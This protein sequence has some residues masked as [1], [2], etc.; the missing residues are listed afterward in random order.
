MLIR[1]GIFRGLAFVR[2]ITMTTIRIVQKTTSDGTLSLQIP[3]DCPDVE[4]SVLIVAQPVQTDPANPAC[5]SEWPE[6]F[7]DRTFG[8]IPDETFTRPP[9]GELPRAVEL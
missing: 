4:Y 5:S 7:L 2:G 3:L 8:S 1:P 6:G 9:R